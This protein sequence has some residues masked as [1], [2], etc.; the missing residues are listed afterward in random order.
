[1]TSGRAFINPPSLSLSRSLSLSVFPQSSGI[2]PVQPY[3]GY[4]LPAGR[5]DAEGE[6]GEGAASDPIAQPQQDPVQVP[7]RRY[8][9]HLAGGAPPELVYRRQFGQQMDGEKSE[10]QQ[11]SEENG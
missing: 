6:A 9:R 5:E 8:T 11:G 4:L 3:H 7:I 1:M 2:E 10:E